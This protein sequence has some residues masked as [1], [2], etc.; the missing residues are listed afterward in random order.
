VVPV[1][2]RGTRLCLPPGR[3]L[4]HP[5]LIEVEVLAPISAGRDFDEHESDL[6]ARLRNS[7]R[8]SLLAALDEPD[9]AAA[10]L[11]AART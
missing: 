5:G 6:A 2:I 7:A 3:I 9:L 8:T 11:D 10:D 4:P 1:A